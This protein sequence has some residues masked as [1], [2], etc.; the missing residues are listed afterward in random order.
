M[1][2]M[3]MLIGIDEAGRGPLAGPVAVGLVRA[4]EDF[5]FLTAFP[6]LNDSKKM[7][8]K[9]RERIFELLQERVTAGDISYLVAMPTAEQIDKWRCSPVTLPV[10][11]VIAINS[12]DCRLSPLATRMTD[13]CP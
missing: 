13:K 11:P 9:N 8:E 1:N 10:A 4:T 2:R 5:D 7:T 6:G 12:P 3:K